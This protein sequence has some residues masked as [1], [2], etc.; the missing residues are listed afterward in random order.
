MF[1]YFSQT[2]F[3]ISCN[4]D[5]LHELSNPV[6]WGK[7]RKIFQNVACWKFYPGCLDSENQGLMC[8][9]QASQRTHDVYTTSP[10]RRWDVASTLRRR[11]INVMCPLGS[12]SGH[13]LKYFFSIFNTDWL[14]TKYIFQPFHFKLIATI[15]IHYK[16][17]KGQ[18]LSCICNYPTRY[19]DY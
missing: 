6:F 8:V 12:D 16:G 19:V 17:N 7:I 13:S 5:S 9:Q 15:K 18:W 10:R 2:W 14:V 1:S 11:C 4:G 3:N